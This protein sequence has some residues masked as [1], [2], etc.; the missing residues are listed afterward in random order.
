MFMIWTIVYVLNYPSDVQRGVKDECL[1]YERFLLFSYTIKHQHLAFLVSVR[2]SFAHIL[3][4][5]ISFCGYDMT[6]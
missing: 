2:L 3:V 4:I 1:P 5:I 6:S